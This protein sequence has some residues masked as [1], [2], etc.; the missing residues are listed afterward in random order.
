MEFMYTYDFTNFFSFKSWMRTEL[1][2]YD[3]LEKNAYDDLCEKLKEKFDREVE[4]GI[5]H[6]IKL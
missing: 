5:L 2:C 1:S 4:F 6:E 3:N